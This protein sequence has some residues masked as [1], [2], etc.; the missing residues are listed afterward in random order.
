M[1]GVRAFSELP[2]NEFWELLT[3]GSELTRADEGTATGV[4]AMLLEREQTLAASFDLS[5]DAFREKVID[6]WWTHQLGFLS[7]FCCQDCLAP[8]WHMDLRTL[9]TAAEASVTPILNRLLS[10]KQHFSLKSLFDGI[11]LDRLRGRGP[12]EPPDRAL[13]YVLQRRPGELQRKCLRTRFVRAVFSLLRMVSRSMEVD[14]ILVN[15]RRRIS[16][17]I[18]DRE[19][20]IETWLLR[21]FAILMESGLLVSHGVFANLFSRS[22]VILPIGE[23]ISFSW[24]FGSAEEPDINI[25]R[26]MA[27]SFVSLAFLPKPD[28]EHHIGLHV[29]CSFHDMGLPLDFFT[30]LHAGGWCDAPRNGV[31]EQPEFWRELTGWVSSLHP[32][33]RHALHH[34]K[35]RFLDLREILLYVVLEAMGIGPRVVFVANACEAGSFHIVTEAV[36]AGIF[37]TANTNP[38]QDMPWVAYVQGYQENP[39]V[40]LEV[41][42]LQVILDLEDCNTGNF[43]RVPTESLSAVA[44]VDMEITRNH[45]DLELPRTLRALYALILKSPLMPVGRITRAQLS[46]AVQGGRRRLDNLT[47]SRVRFVVYPS[48]DEHSRTLKQEM[49]DHEKSKTKCSFA[50]LLAAINKQICDFFVSTPFETDTMFGRRSLGELFGFT[51]TDPLPEDGILRGIVRRDTITIQRAGPTEVGGAGAE[52]DDHADERQRPEEEGGMNGTEEEDAEFDPFADVPRSRSLDDQPS[53]I[54]EAA[55]APSGPP[56]STTPPP[57]TRAP[58]ETSLRLALEKLAWLEAWLDLRV[59]S[60]LAGL[61]RLVEHFDEVDTHFRHA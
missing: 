24:R 46:Q 51:D 15:L 3:S 26:Y 19:L 9:F 44:I 38:G 59:S 32:T 42:L 39:A 55:P 52:E 31:K 16:D 40:F 6:K 35:S 1:S 20:K 49:M 7:A 47:R 28:P 36:A 33:D 58:L 17:Q 37:P 23:K 21:P 45:P 8:L 2:L 48:P 12:V 29:V 56:P 54:G 14:A 11:D 27:L 10:Q 22:L 30:K 13:A 18:L 34:V 25:P 50:E 53:G 41:A 5:V 57:S 60:M 61:D 4:K 43:C